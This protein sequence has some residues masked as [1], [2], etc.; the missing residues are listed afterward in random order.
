MPPCGVTPQERRGQCQIRS[1]FDAP[2]NTYGVLGV[3]A[4][5]TFLGYAITL[6]NRVAL[7]SAW[8]H[9]IRPVGKDVGSHIPIRVCSTND[10][11]AR[12]ARQLTEMLSINVHDVNPKTV[13]VRIKRYLCAVRRPDRP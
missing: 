5:R 11:I 4:F 10:V 9:I 8:P 6:G 3:F 7:M 13:A 12:V 1:L 2:G